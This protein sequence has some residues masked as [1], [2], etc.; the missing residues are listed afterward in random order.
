MLCDGRVD[1]CSEPGAPCCWKQWPLPQE[2][3]VSGSETGGLISSTSLHSLHHLTIL[4]DQISVD[5]NQRH[6]A[7]RASPS[8]VPG[9]SWYPECRSASQGSTWEPQLSS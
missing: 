4:N 3:S 7:L 8:G 9:M 6:Q 5:T 2:Q 1:P